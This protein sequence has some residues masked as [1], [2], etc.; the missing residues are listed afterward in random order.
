MF[1]IDCK[2]TLEIDFTDV[3]N[4]SVDIDEFIF[5]LDHIHLNYECLS[6]VLFGSHY[7]HWL[8]NAKIV[9]NDA[10]KNSYDAA[11]QRLKITTLINSSVEINWFVADW[12]IFEFDAFFKV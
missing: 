10:A 6:T 3:F 11:I 2:L 8:H 7:F 4:L 5:I 12:Y 9:Y 1:H